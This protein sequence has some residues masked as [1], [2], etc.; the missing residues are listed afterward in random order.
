MEKLDYL[1][2]D[3]GMGTML[4]AAGLPMG[5]T[6]E[7]WNL[8]EPEKVTAVHRRYVEAGSRLLYTNT[9]GAN[10]LK[11]ARCG[12][13]PAELI[14]GAVRCAR[15]AAGG[16]SV[17]VA[18]DV[19]PIG[20]LLEPLGTLRFEEAYE[21]FREQVVAGEEAGADHAADIDPGAGYDRVMYR[22][23]VDGGDWAAAS[24]FATGEERRMAHL[25]EQCARQVIEL[26]AVEGEPRAMFTPEAVA[27]EGDAVAYVVGCLRQAGLLVAKADGEWWAD[28]SGAA[29]FSVFRMLDTHRRRLL[30]RLG[31]GGTLAFAPDA[32]WSL[33]GVIPVV[34][35]LYG[36]V[37]SPI[38]VGVPETA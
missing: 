17:R 3:G 5:E 32:S 31:W 36:Y 23:A 28:I 20:Q 37:A 24:R 21:L 33:D 38:R 12:H 2:L 25:V 27:A 6:P 29:A 10:R 35:T 22:L 4:Q 11:T 19:G 1:L 26:K 18:L 16:E 15:A 9:F 7:L 34:G 14:A 8:T 13:S 30:K